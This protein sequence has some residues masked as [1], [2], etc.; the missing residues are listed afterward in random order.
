MAATDKNLRE[1]IKKLKK[2]KE[3][4][5]K[6]LVR[7]LSSARRKRV[8]VNLTKIDKIGKD[9]EVIIVPGKVLGNGRLTKNLSVCAWSFSKAAEKKIKES[10]KIVSWNE[11]IEKNIKG[12]IVV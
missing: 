5:Y 1:L 3:K 12:R 9:G 10:G 4:F 11:I 6:V 7:S 2:H 8:A